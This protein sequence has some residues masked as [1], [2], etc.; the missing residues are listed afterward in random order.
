MYIPYFSG[1]DNGGLFECQ[2]R[3]GAITAGKIDVYMDDLDEALA[4]GRREL[5]V[6]VINDNEGELRVK[7]RILKASKPTY[8]YA[9]RIGE[10]F[11]ATKHK[12]VEFPEFA[13]RIECNDDMWIDGCWVNSADCEEVDGTANR[14]DALE[15]RIAELESQLRVAQEDIV[16]IEAGVTDDIKRLESDITDLRT[17]Y[18]IQTV[19]PDGQRITC[20]AES[21]RKAYGKEPT[22][23]EIVAKAIADV[24]ELKGR[25]RGITTNSEGNSTFR[26][27]ISTVDFVVNSEKRTVVALVKG[28]NTLELFEKGI[29]K[30]APNDVFNAHIGKAIAL[31]RALG[32]DVPAEYLNAPQPEKAR[33]G[34][35]VH[36]RRYH[37]LESRRPEFDQLGYGRAFGIEREVGWLGEDQFDI[38]DD[39]VS[40]EKTESSR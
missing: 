24:A 21:L 7:I 22:R 8:W 28:R 5:D 16:L 15:K 18:A 3:G 23:D 29:A 27:R 35:V 32:L 40:T 14:M 19:T 30:C 36:G 9:D 6:A 31:R 1:E 37:T 10:V 2:D 26:H 13:Y 11:E 34:D 4:F 17:A 38:I 25:M 33:V 39:T 12:N 20:L